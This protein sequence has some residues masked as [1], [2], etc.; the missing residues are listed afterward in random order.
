MSIPTIIWSVTAVRE[1][2]TLL[3]SYPVGAAPWD[4][5]SN[6]DESETQIQTQRWTLYARTV[7]AII[8]D[9]T[10]RGPVLKAIANFLLPFLRVFL[11]T[12]PRHEHIKF[13]AIL[14]E[15]KQDQRQHMHRDYDCHIEDELPPGG[16]S[17]SII[18]PLNGCRRLLM[19]P[20]GCDE[21]TIVVS[22]GQILIFDSSLWHCGYTNDL[23]E[24]S[25]CLHMYA[26]M[27]ANH[28]PKNFVFRH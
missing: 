1:L 3:R 13:G 22:E 26:A 19:R 7:G 2:C 27:N 17:L 9:T 28:I 8:S 23:N 20:T 24:S 18:I 11:L 14:S 5:L 4:I 12:Y 21:Q 25:V 6:F 15:A 16:R 10:A